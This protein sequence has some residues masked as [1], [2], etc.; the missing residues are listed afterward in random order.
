LKYFERRRKAKLYRQWVERDGL[1]P[2]AVHP[3]KL[4]DVHLQA[5]RSE[6]ISLETN[7]SLTVHV[8]YDN[9][10]ATHPEAAGD[11]LTEIDRRQ[12]RVPRLFILLGATI[13]IVCVGLILLIVYSC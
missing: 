10:V 5:S 6:D 9:R 12:L 1:P 7:E 8:E 3:E 13:L 11:M 2:E 4:E